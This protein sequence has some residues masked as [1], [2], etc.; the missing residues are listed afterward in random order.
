VE[1]WDAALL[2]NK[3][4]DD[5]AFGLENLNIRT[6]DS[7]VTLYIQHPIPIP[8]PG[9]KN[10]VGLKPLKLTNKACHIIFLSLSSFVILS[11]GAKEDEEATSAGR[12]AR[13]A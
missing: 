9:D 2:A 11:A 4:Y 8:A 5:L 6:R 12:T 7:P 13:Q 1:W 3:T 10:K